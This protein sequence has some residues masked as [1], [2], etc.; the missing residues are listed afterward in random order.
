MGLPPWS[1]CWIKAPAR[2]MT[3]TTEMNCWMLELGIG[4]GW[5]DRLVRFVERDGLFS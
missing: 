2:D 3:R 4:G 5:E 1:C